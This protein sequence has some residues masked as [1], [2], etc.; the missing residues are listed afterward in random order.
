MVIFVFFLIN[1]CYLIFTHVNTA[2]PRQLLLFEGQSCC[3]ILHIRT[4][5]FSCWNY[6]QWLLAKLT[7][8]QIGKKK[9]SFTYNPGKKPWTSPFPFSM[10]FP[11]QNMFHSNNNYNKTTLSQHWEGERGVSKLVDPDC[12]LFKI[13]MYNKPQIHKKKIYT[14]TASYVHHFRSVQGPSP[15]FPM[16]FISTRSGEAW[17]KTDKL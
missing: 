1:F 17:I 15:P 11:L 14:P 6:I 12:S 3:Y 4:K 9:K 8:D 13:S 16:A 2:R 5:C 10:L 7:S